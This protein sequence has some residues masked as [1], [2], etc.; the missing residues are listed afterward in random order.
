MA[1]SENED[2]KMATTDAL[3]KLPTVP[4][5]ELVAKFHA[6]TTKVEKSGTLL[7]TRHGQPSM[8]MMSLDRYRALEKAT[9]PDLAQLTLEFDVM[10]AGMQAPDAI[11][12]MSSAFAMGP[13]ELGHAAI[14][15]SR[16]GARRAAV[17][18]EFATPGPFVTPPTAK[19]RR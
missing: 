14:R 8:V 7:V 15:Q 16:E 4:A 3:E 17:V 2:W 11:T 6:T 18:D 19:A 13:L 10:Y 9:T 12:R 5:S 1:C